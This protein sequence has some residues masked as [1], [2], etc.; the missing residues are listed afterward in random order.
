MFTL[1]PNINISYGRTMITE[2][3]G[4][5]HYCFAFAVAFFLVVVAASRKIA[6]TIPVSIPGHHN[7]EYVAYHDGDDPEQLALLF[8]KN[9]NFYNSACVSGVH[10]AIV[11]RR[12]WVL[13]NDEF[14]MTEHHEMKPVDFNY[15]APRFDALVATERRKGVEFLNREGYVIFKNVATEAQVDD[16]FEKLWAF[17]KDRFKVDRDDINTWDAI[18]SNEFGIILRF[19]IGQSD[20]M[21]SVRQNENVRNIFAEVWDVGVDE[22]IT[23]FGGT[24]VFRPA[25]C[26]NRWRT[27]EKWF[28]VDQNGMSSP[29]RQ[30][31]QGSM[32]LTK[33]TPESGGMVVIPKSWHQHDE[34]SE[35]ASKYWGADKDTQFLMVPPSDAVLQRASPVFITSEPGDL[36]LWDSRTVHCNTNLRYRVDESEFSVVE[37]E[38]TGSASIDEEDEEIGEDVLDLRDEVLQA[39]TDL[40]KTPK[41]RTLEALD[42]MHS[43]SNY[44]NF[45]INPE[46]KAGSAGAPSSLQ[47]VVALVSMAPKHFASEEVL[48]KR[49]LAY[50]NEQTTT[51][52]PFRFEADEPPD[53]TVR[54][55]E[56]LNALQLSLIG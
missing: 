45:P 21:W 13:E 16:Y 41:Q 4:G 28:H 56:E 22:L 9:I 51:H 33:Q 32:S 24:V 37:V 44:N 36:I 11:K 47:R 3:M 25:N 18:P 6:F 19:G 49:R 15:S 2:K 31:V 7:P 43:L 34:L 27:S 50:V 1:V 29:G 46:C 12:K 10:G 52:W 38:D 42:R 35:R 5:Q 54:K 48:Q 26:T 39:P 17:L 8:C 40:E 53:K 55:V 14:A 30:T 23:D 20:Y